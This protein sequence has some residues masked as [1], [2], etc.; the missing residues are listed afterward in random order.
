MAAS[1]RAPP[2]HDASTVVQYFAV[3]IRSFITPASCIAN[4]VLTVSGEVKVIDFAFSCKYDGPPP[5]GWAVSAL[6]EPIRVAKQT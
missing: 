4:L 5:R 2:F 6:G 1:V 3:K